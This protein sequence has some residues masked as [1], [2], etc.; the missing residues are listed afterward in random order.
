MFRTAR[1][2]SVVFLILAGCASDERYFEVL[3]EQQAAWNELADVLESVKDEKSLVGAQKELSER[4][5][6][7]ESVAQKAQ[8][9]PKPSAAVV[10][11]LEQKKYLLQRAVER[12]Q[13]EVRRIRR[14]VPGGEA[15]CKKFG[16]RFPGLM[17][18]VQP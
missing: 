14:D 2:G 13:G 5:A 17:S 18:A 12:A 1:I 15:F 8:A 7:F 11:Q 10:E 16:A 6:K 9:L 4:E 3:R